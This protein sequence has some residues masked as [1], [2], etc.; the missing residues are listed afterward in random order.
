MKRTGCVLIL[1][2]FLLAVPGCTG[3]RQFG[4]PHMQP[5]PQ[6]VQ[7]KRAVKFDPYPDPN[8][9]P[10]TPGVRPLWYETP[11]GERCTTPKFERI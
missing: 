4:T 3:N 8:I 2:V 5:A 6:E 11:S 10:S 1:V 9:G 7:R